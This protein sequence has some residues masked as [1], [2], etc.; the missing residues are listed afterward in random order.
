[1]EGGQ[2]SADEHGGLGY[3]RQRW[4]PHPAQIRNRDGGRRPGR[5][6]G[7]LERAGRKPAHSHVP[8]FESGSGYL[9]HPGVHGYVRMDDDCHFDERLGCMEWL[10]WSS[11]NGGWE[12]AQCDRDRHHQHPYS[13]PAV[14]EIAGGALTPRGRVR[15]RSH[16]IQQ[17]PW[18][19]PP[20]L[21][22]CSGKF[23]P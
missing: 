5:I 8:A 1:M 20:T 13:E 10:C 4:H 23:M 15:A 6:P 7:G 17:Q 3:A 11:G 2:Q 14:S 19:H 18:P 9:C 12:F 16:T 22:D 21:F